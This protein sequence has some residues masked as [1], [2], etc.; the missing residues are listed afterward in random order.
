MDRRNFLKGIWWAWVIALSWCWSVGRVLDA[1]PWNI[2]TLLD[3]NRET[4]SME[5]FIAKMQRYEAHDNLINPE[6]GTNEWNMWKFQSLVKPMLEDSLSVEDIEKLKYLI[7]DELQSGY[8]NDRTQG[9]RKYNAEKVYDDNVFFWNIAW[10]IN[11]QKLRWALIDTRISTTLNIFSLDEVL[12]YTA[13]DSRLWDA[14]FV[15]QDNL[16]NYYFLY[17]E[18]GRLKYASPTS[19]GSTILWETPNT[20]L[21]YSE[22]RDLAHYYL[23]DQN[24]WLSQE[25]LNTLRKTRTIGGS[26]PYSRRVLRNGKIDGYYTHIWNVTG[27][28][29][30]HGCIRLP[31]L[32]AY[33]LFYDGNIGTPIHYLEDK[34]LP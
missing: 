8:G 2:W 21:E 28:K 11:I 32:W 23:D 30:S 33:I 19:P 20:G 31:A 34:R 9:F 25:E 10:E 13:Y 14:G 5:D 7:S 15:I 12:K 16:W 26:M 1:T 4:E 27:Q 29:E 17:Y 24:K 18:G 22:Y 6:S 3:Y